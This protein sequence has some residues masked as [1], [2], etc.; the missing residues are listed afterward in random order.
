MATLISFS[1]CEDL[2]GEI[3]FQQLAGLNNHYTVQSEKKR[4]TVFM[5]TI[6]KR[7][8]VKHQGKEKVICEGLINTKDIIQMFKKVSEHRVILVHKRAEGYHELKQERPSVAEASLMLQSV[9]LLS[10]LPSDT[11]SNK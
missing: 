4:E 2:C 6:Y 11:N 10:P 8:R 1:Y 9:F 3:K 5:V 7:S